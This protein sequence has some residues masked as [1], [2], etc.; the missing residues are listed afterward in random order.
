M[1][2]I[3]GRMHYA[4]DL[5]KYFANRHWTFTCDN[6]ITLINSLKGKDITT[7]DVDISKPRT[8][9]VLMNVWLGIRRYLLK[10]NDNTISMARIKYRM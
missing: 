4:L 1:K 10:E 5:M 8:E 3:V 2:K 9:D 6:Y 7:Y